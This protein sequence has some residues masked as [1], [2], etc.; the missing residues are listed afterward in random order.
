MLT[1][2]AIPARHSK[3]HVGYPTLRPS[4]LLERIRASSNRGDM[5]DHV[6]NLQ[7]PWGACNSR[8]GGGPWKD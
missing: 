3:Q 1:S 7:L 2:A 5:T 4:K 6:S 8:R